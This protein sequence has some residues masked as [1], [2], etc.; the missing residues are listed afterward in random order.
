[1]G[2]QLGMKLRSNWT[3]LLFETGVSL[4]CWQDYGDQPVVKNI[5]HRLSATALCGFLRFKAI[6]N[7]LFLFKNTL[8]F[9]LGAV[10]IGAPLEAFADRVNLAK[11]QNVTASSQDSTFAPSFVV[12]GLVSNFHS[13]RTPDTG[14]HWL[15]I[16]YPRD[17]TLASVHLYLGLDNLP[18]TQI[19]ENFKLQFYGRSGWVDVPGGSVTGNVDT[20]VNLIFA[21]TVTADRFRLYSTD[22]GKHV[23]RQIAMFPPNS[24][25][26]VEQ[27]FPMGTDV[28]LNLTYKRPSSASSANLNNIFGPGYAKNAFDGYIDNKSRWL[29]ANATGEY[30]EVDLLAPH[31]IGSAHLYSGFIDPEAEIRETVQPIPNFKLQWQDGTEW[32]DI[33]G[34]NISGNTEVALILD[35]SE[36]V[37]TSRVRLVTTSDFNS[38]I[39]QL[40]IFPPRD[41]GYS[42]GRE[43]IDA[44]PPTAKWDDFSDS[45]YRIRIRPDPDRRLGLVE[46]EAIFANNA[47]GADGLNWQLLLNYRDGSYRIRHE[48]TGLALA[49][50]EISKEPDTLVIGE[51]YSGMPHQEWFLEYTSA[52][53]FRLINA[54]SGLALEPLNGNQTLGTPLAVGPPSDSVLQHWDAALQH[55]HPKKGIAAT[56]NSNRLVPWGSGETWLENS[57]AL[58]GDRAS[59][60]YSWGRQS[61]ED[62]PFMAADHIFNPMQWGNFN[63]VHGS[64]QGPVDN[65]RSEL[66][67]AASAVHLM[68]FNEPD[69]DGQANMSAD[70]A[71][72]R[73]PRLLAMEVPLVSPAPASAF[74]GWL[75]D[76]QTRAEDRGYRFDYTGVHW[77]G[78]PIAGGAAS[79]NNL[80]N[81][82]QNNFNTFGRPVWLTEFSAVEWNQNQSWTHSDNYEFL[83]EF[84]WRAES[85]PWLKRYS[86]FKFVQGPTDNPNQSAP[87]RTDAPRSNTRNEDGSLTAFGELYAAWDGV[88]EILPLKAYHLHNRG[89]YERGRQGDDSA[90]EM[91]S[92]DADT[93]GTQWFLAPGE[94]PGT[95]RVISLLDGRPLRLDSQENVTLGEMGQIDSSVEWKLVADAHG[96]FFIEH[97][98]NALRLRSTDGGFTTVPAANTGNRLKW[99]LIPPLH[100]EPVITAAIVDGLTATPGVR[101]IALEWSVP[102]PSDVERYTIYRS[103][104]PAGPFTEVVAE[105][106]DSNWTDTGLAPETTYYYAIRSL[107]TSGLQ[108]DLSSVAGATTLHV[109]ATYESWAEIVFPNDPEVDTSPQGNPDGDVLVN[110]FEYVFLT[111]PTRPDGAQLTISQN[112]EKAIQLH[113]PW[114]RHAIDYAWR[115]RHGHDLNDPAPWPIADPGQIETV[116]E[117]DLDRTTVTMP[118]SLEAKAFFILEVHAT[119]EAP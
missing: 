114:N 35:F 90:L 83:A 91:V 92:L 13:F 40:L 41:G 77:Y 14:P 118:S 16:N 33:P 4:V 116:T 37:T 48:K 59:W 107:T 20:E 17:V 75:A 76:F 62:F 113:F 12:D 85:L 43:V 68:G 102:E 72:V 95:Y 71:I 56:H 42:L 115:I 8:A 2:I 104:S 119:E 6:A 21:R 98:V 69:K 39:Q 45:T 58:F 70:I 82:L 15:E 110:L 61:R 36:N 1:M 97:P 34:T 23:I 54:F 18:G 80:I 10:V 30:L 65:L 99:R 117:G 52:S 101:E 46:G 81:H 55:H 73:W 50:A 112:E 24:V 25:D 88:A 27:G 57:Y 108:S 49:L 28:R 74:N 103:D 47:L 89:S 60:S 100:P 7:R 29:S 78:S 87:D 5:H 3:D 111:D 96:R 79:A 11:Y 38:R 67:S 26:G 109:F 31:V 32:I 66:Q 9:A 106:T 94:T 63:W 19:F 51:T 105:V 84:M 22:T 93:T 86:V 53:K 64:N 44:P